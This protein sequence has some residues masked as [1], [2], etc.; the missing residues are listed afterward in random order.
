MELEYTVFVVGKKTELPTY[1]AEDLAEACQFAMTN[2]KPPYNVLYIV[3]KPDGSRL[4]INDQR[5]YLEAMP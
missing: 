1:L 2:N 4:S 5:K 3:E